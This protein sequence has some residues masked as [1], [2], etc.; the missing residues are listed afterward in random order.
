MT[1]DYANLSNT[2]NKYFTAL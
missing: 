1:N 2:V